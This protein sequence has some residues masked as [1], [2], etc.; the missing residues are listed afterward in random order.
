MPT[1]LD[2]MRDIKNG[3][4]KK[5]GILFEKYKNPLFGYFYRNT[6][7]QDK[8]EDLVQSVFY[9]ILKYRKNFNGEGKFT[10]WMYH[11]AHNVLYDSVYKKKMKTEPIEN[12]D[13]ALR[14]ETDHEASLINDENISVLKKAL[15]MMHHEQ[16]EILILSKYQNLKYREIGD[17]LNCTESTVKVRV[18]R[19][20]EDLRVIY[21]RLEGSAV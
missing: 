16:R 8:S 2:V 17:I 5:L 6:N 21:H 13:F 7:N 12:I 11:I 14:E 19:A 3:D 1:D 9:R 15:D 10:S 20:M 4:I 18:F